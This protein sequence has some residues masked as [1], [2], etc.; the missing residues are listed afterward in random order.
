LR[1]RTA[2]FSDSESASLLSEGAAR[3]AEQAQ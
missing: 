3:L 1:T 2:D